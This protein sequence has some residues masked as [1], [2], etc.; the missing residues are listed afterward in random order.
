MLSEAEAELASA[1]GSTA[2]AA[3]VHTA[4]TGR[5]AAAAQQPK[6]GQQQ[7]PPGGV[8]AA[9]RGWLVVWEAARFFGCVLAC[10]VVAEGAVQE[11]PGASEPAR[12]CRP[13]LG[14]ETH[15]AARP[16]WQQRVFM[17]QFGALLR[18]LGARPS[19]AQPVGAGAGE[20]PAPPLP[21]PLLLALAHLIQAAPAAVLRTAWAQVLPWVP[22]CLS[23]LLTASQRRRGQGAAATA[24]GAGS[25]SSSQLQSAEVRE[26]ERQEKELALSLLGMLCEAL[27]TEEGAAGMLCTMRLLGSLHGG[28]KKLPARLGPRP[29]APWLP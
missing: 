10:P 13:D 29:H 16:L 18:S 23:E 3:G 2:G 15:A 5:K 1:G 19:A 22:R 24:G 8:W 20:G 9:H 14:P 17:L 25:G 12:C 11:E 27:M 21:S 6:G 28:G 26:V 4:G 7:D